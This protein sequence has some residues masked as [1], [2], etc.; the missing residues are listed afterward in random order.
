MKNIEIEPMDADAFAEFGDVI[1]CSRGVPTTINEGMCQRFSDLANL[2]H[3]SSGRLGVSIFRSRL[4]TLPYELDLVERHPLGP[5]AF[6]PM[7]G[8]AFLVTVARDVGGSPGHPRAFLTQRWTGVNIRRNAWHG[9]LTPLSGT[10]LFWVVDWIGES[11]NLIEHR[12][13]EV[14]IV[15]E[16]CI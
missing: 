11:G 16:E 6:L 8:E 10:G 5:Q 12:W 2:A 14:W 7:D 9:V 15:G 1:E 4:R 13:P 3:D